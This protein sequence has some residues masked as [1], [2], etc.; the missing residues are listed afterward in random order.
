MCTVAT[1]KWTREKDT[2]PMRRRKGRRRREVVGSVKGRRTRAGKRSGKVLSLYDRGN[3]AYI[4]SNNHPKTEPRLR[5][6]SYFLRLEFPLQSSMKRTYISMLE[7]R[8]QLGRKISRENNR[9]TRHDYKL[10]HE[11][12]DFTRATRHTQNGNRTE[13]RSV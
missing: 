9:D 10:D 12:S 13:S 6:V 7:H 4:M 11:T 5:N 2:V 8:I 1:K 3:I